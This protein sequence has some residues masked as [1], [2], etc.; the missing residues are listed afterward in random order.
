MPTQKCP[1]CKVELEIPA[2][3]TPGKKIRCPECDHSFLLPGPKP[4]AAAAPKPKSAF[5]SS[6][7]PKAP[8]AK[9]PVQVMEVIEDDEED[10]KLPPKP[11]KKPMKVTEVIEDDEDDKPRPKLKKKKKKKKVQAQD[12][13]FWK[14]RM[15]MT[16]NGLGLL[17]LGVAGIAIAYFGETRKAT[18]LYI[19]GA[20]CILCGIGAMGS[21]MLGLTDES[22][23]SDSDDD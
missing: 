18:T 11:K 8:A 1:G 14:T 22:E 7:A 23:R 6:T 5:P 4:A 2:G 10:D 19:A 17:G 3:T 13:P 21:G 9:K 12:V 16:L 15:G 20:V